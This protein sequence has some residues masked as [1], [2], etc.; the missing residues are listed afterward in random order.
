MHKPTHIS[1]SA[2]SAIIFHQCCSHSGGLGFGLEGWRALVCHRYIAFLYINPMPDLLT[3]TQSAMG[4]CYRYMAMRDAHQL[5]HLHF[6]HN[7]CPSQLASASR[8]REPGTRNDSPYNTRVETQ[9]TVDGNV[10]GVIQPHLEERVSP[11]LCN[12]LHNINN[13]TSR[14]SNK[15]RTKTQHANETPIAF[16]GTSVSRYPP[17]CNRP[18]CWG[19]ACSSDLSS[20]RPAFLQTTIDDHCCRAG[21]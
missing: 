20:R 18:N 8:H 4:F 9:R 7:L 13:L 2:T 21:W 6:K 3:Q 11:P 12:P 16:C 19:L 5:F 10:L 1:A 17:A 14:H 15:T